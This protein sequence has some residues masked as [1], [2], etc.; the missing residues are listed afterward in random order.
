[1]IN[2]RALSYIF[3]GQRGVRHT[4]NITIYK[5]HLYVFS[6]FSSPFFYQDYPD[7]KYIKNSI[8]NLY[9]VSS[10]LLQLQIQFCKITNIV[11]IL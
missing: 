2:G 3:L 6:F 10:M 8:G 1:M 11:K 5:Y 9:D 4:D 7:Y